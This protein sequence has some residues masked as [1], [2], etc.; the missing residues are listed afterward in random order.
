MLIFIVCLLCAK[1]YS[2]SFKKKYLIHL[3]HIILNIS[4]KV[5]LSSHLTERLSNLA[6]II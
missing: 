5:L 6:N 1:L 2:K 3:I 4:G